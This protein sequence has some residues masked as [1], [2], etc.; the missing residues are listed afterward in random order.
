MHEY[1]SINLNK[2][3]SQYISTQPHSKMHSE[4]ACSYSLFLLLNAD[5][6]RSADGR[7]L[8]RG[9]DRRKLKAKRPLGITFCVG[10]K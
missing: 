5:K 9:A 4:C 10:M 7:L 8:S 2:F 3:Y 6:M 1:L